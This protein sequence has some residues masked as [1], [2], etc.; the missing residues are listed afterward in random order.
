MIVLTLCIYDSAPYN[1]CRYFF[2]FTHRVLFS[3]HKIRLMAQTMKFSALTY[4]LTLQY[5]SLRNRYLAGAGVPAYRYE[6]RRTSH[7]CNELL[8]AGEVINTIIFA[9][10]D[11]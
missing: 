3:P 8:I 7:V 11:F 5:F 10:K 6:A 4:L 2:S 1:M 9:G